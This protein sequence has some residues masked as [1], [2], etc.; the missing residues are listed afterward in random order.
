MRLQLFTYLPYIIAV[1][2]GAL[3]TGLS[4]AWW[5]QLQR[6]WLFVLLGLLA[7]YLLVPAMFLL[8]DVILPT[9]GAGYFFEFNGQSESKGERLF[10]GGVLIIVIPLLFYFAAA[11]G[12][13]WLLRLWLFKP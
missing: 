12:A 3:A 9:S 7:V 13:L 5:P 8:A 11:V 2:P 6:P 4:L 10:A 1:I